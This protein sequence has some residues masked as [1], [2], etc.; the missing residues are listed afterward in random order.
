[1]HLF[2]RAAPDEGI[3]R[4]QVHG[5]ISDAFLVLVF[6]EVLDRRCSK[7]MVFPEAVESRFPQIVDSLREEL[8]RLGDITRSSALANSHSSHLL[9]DV[10]DATT[11]GKA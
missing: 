5:V 2:Q 7:G 4:P 9:V 10:P 11:L 8:L 3:E 6:H 1:M